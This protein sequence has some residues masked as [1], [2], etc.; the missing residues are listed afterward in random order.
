MKAAINRVLGLTA[1]VGILSISGLL[2]G[3]NGANGASP[4]WSSLQ[5]PSEPGA[6]WLGLGTLGVGFGPMGI[7]RRIR[8]LRKQKHMTLEQVG[9]VFGITRSAVAAWE[10]GGAR[11]HLKKLPTLAQVLDTSVEYLLNGKDEA[12]ASSFTDA[13]LAPSINSHIPLISWKQADQWAE[14][15]DH[16]KPQEIKVWFPR[17]PGLNPN[18]FALRVQGVSM[19]PQF[20]D[21]AIIFVDPNVTPQHLD[22]VVVKLK[23]VEEPVFRQL[24]IDGNRKFLKILNPDLPGPKL[25]EVKHDIICRGVVYA[26]LVVVSP[27]LFF[28]QAS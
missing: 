27:K 7:G 22:F 8:S 15:A 12:G 17:I 14:I 24:L 5:P 26:E 28:P 1:L 20:Q 13:P 18:L 10:R 4:G 21:G 2:P 16:L 19:E 6:L 3:A 11:P 9:S 23:G 25:T